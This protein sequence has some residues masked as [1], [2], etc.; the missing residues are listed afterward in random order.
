MTRE[1]LACYLRVARLVR[2][3]QA[4]LAK[5]IEKQKDTESDE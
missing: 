3:H 1:H 2:A 5:P 4:K